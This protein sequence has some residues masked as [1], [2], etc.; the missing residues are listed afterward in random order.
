MFPFLIL[1]HSAWTLYQKRLQKV[2]CFL[3]VG[4]LSYLCYDFLV[5]VF[6]CSFTI[7]YA[8][9][10]VTAQYIMGVCVRYISY[11]IV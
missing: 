8:T 4:L 6:S 5:C 11:F 7:L 10:K 9:H 2:S 3:F 1:P